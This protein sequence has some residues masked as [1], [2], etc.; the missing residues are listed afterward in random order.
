MVESDTVQAVRKH[1][2]LI[3]IAVDKKHLLDPAGKLPEIPEEF[4]PVSVSA[5]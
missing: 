4:V 1:L 3:R 5:E 2:L